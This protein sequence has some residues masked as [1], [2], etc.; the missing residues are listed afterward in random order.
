[1]LF[2]NSPQDSY[3]NVLIDIEKILNQD[4]FSEITLNL[5][6]CIPSLPKVKWINREIH[7][8]Y[9]N[10]FQILWKLLYYGCN[11][12]SRKSMYATIFEELLSW[13]L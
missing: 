12:R 5:W 3:K 7:E 9:T 4:A 6:K 8:Y 13:L 2:S 1:M 11:G 10:R